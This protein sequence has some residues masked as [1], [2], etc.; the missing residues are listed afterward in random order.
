[1][2]HLLHDITKFTYTSIKQTKT[3]NPLLF[4]PQNLKKKDKRIQIMC[5]CL[6]KTFKS[7]QLNDNDNFWAKFIVGLL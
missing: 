1:M 6:F 4:S 7:T 3:N 2:V 5:K